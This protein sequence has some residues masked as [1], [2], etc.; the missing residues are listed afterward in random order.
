MSGAPGAID[1]RVLPDPDVI[2]R[3][4][5]ARLRREVE[6]VVRATLAERTSL[7]EATRAELLAARRALP[8]VERSLAMAEHRRDR[9]PI[10]RGTT[11]HAA[12]DRDPRVA[13]LFAARGLPRCLDCAVGADETLAEAAYGEGFDVDAL[14]AELARPPA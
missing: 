9:T 2:E 3:R 12:H 1:G 13:A 6:R 5:R 7:V 10:H 14:L 4:L 11:V 8:A